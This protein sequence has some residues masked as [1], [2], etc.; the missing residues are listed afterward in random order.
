MDF[1]LLTVPGWVSNLNVTFIKV[2]FII[3]LQSE[4]T[5]PQTSGLDVEKKPCAYAETCPDKHRKERVLQLC[6]LANMSLALK[7]LSGGIKLLS[8][9]LTSQP[10]STGIIA[11][12]GT[13]RVS[14]SAFT[15]RSHVQH[16]QCQE[17]WADFWLEKKHTHTV[18]T[19]TQTTDCGAAAEPWQDHLFLQKSAQ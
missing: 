5:S 13:V 19:F 15:C 8:M 3:L 12:T 9:E 2:I 11:Y 16:I 14:V 10:K 18:F 4:A 7:S 6:V 17:V 1:I